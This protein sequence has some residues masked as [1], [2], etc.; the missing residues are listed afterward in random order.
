M[1]NILVIRKMQIQIKTTIGHHF[2]PIWMAII[3]KR[4][5]V[6]ENLDTLLAGM[7]NGAVL[8]AVPQNVKHRAITWP[9]SSTL[10]YV[11]KRTKNLCPHGNLYMNVHKSIICNCQKV[12]TTPMSISWWMDNQ[13]GS[14]GC[15]MDKSWKHFCQ[16][17]KDRYKR[18]HLIWFNYEMSKIDKSIETESRLVA[19]RGRGMGSDC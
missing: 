19:V 5:L 1:L 16:T 3:K 14:A 6:N 12:G 15:N 13:M 10:R 18:P 8:S 17:K 4:E 2:T 7:R 11:P 9:S